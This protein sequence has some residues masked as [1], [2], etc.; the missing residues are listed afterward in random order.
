MKL[1][2][3]RVFAL[4]FCFCALKVTHAQSKSPSFK[5]IAFYTAK[6]DAAHISFV[7]EANKWFPKIGKEYNFVYCGGAISSAG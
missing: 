3:K 5:V 2:L 6:E 7:H 1:M 4:L